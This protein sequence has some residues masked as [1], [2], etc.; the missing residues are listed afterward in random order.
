MNG[1]T[2]C[3]LQLGRASF[4]VTAHHVIACYKKR[5]RNGEVLN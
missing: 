2:G 3:I 1:A 4:I 5:I